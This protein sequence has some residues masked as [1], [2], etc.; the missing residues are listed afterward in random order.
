MKKEKNKLLFL[1]VEVA[2]NVPVIFL[3]LHVMSLIF[4]A[5]ISF[6]IIL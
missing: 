4:A 2:T 5:D 3:M 1:D 6:G